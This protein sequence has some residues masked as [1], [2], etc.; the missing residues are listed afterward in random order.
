MKGVLFGWVDLGK[1]AEAAIKFPDSP[2]AG[3]P[4]E[5]QT[6]LADLLRGQKVSISTSAEGDAGTL[7]ITI[8]KGLLESGSEA[9]AAILAARRMQSRMRNN[10]RDG[11][12]PRRRR[13]HEIGRITHMRTLF[14]SLC[15]TLALSLALL[16]SHGTP[17]R[18][19]D[20][21]AK[22]GA[23]AN[24]PG[25]RQIDRCAAGLRQAGGV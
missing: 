8:T 5:I 24:R 4:P 20:A 12:L 7:D 13:R 6:K 10:R 18:A 22:P 16:F 17:V 15:G 11:F 9:D 14:N 1:S 3:L 23:G 2:L 21:A 19:D 25:L